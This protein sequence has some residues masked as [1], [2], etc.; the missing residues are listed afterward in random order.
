MTHETAALPEC[1]HR[2]GFRTRP[3]VIYFF[4]LISAVALGNGLSDS[5]YANYFKEVYNIDAFQRGLIEG[6]RELPGMLCA[7]VI[8]A[9]GFLGDLRVALIAQLLSLIGITSL[10]LLTPSFGGMLIFLFTASM[11]MH[12]FLPVQDAIGMEL[13]EPGQVGRRLGQFFSVRSAFTLLSGFLVFFG[14]RL[15]F[16][17]FSQP[18]KW[19]FLTASAAF[20]CAALMAVLMIRHLKPAH[21]APVRT[22]LF[23]RRQYRYYYLLTT[24]HGVQKQI[25]LVYGTWVIVDLLLKKADTLAL[26]TIAVGFVSIFFMNRIGHWSDRYGIKRMMYLDALTF[27][28]IYIV[29]GFTV[30]GISSGTLPRNVFTVGFVYLLFVL[31]RLSMQIGV[32]KSIYLRSIAW[33]TEEVTSTLSL[34]V[35]LDHLISIIAAIAGG[36]VW[37]RWGSHWVF[38]LAAAFSLG[39]LY[40]AWRVQPQAEQAEA[41]RQKAAAL[42]GSAA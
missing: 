35:S 6:P 28:G 36:Y 9:I 31:D 15:G 41:A 42:Q 1:K 4:I 22:R 24:L 32:V 20:L 18:V 40:V 26:L 2:S 19:V 38:F 11:G 5:I 10:G 30:W 12:L 3:E 21:K 23:F 8:G 13:A 27:I 37:S 16:F 29:Y 7:L 14:F 33:S 34:G 25:A 39:N 17:S